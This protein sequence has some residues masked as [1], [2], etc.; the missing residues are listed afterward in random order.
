MKN[1]IIIP[2]RFKSSRFPG[3][4]LALIN[5]RSLI[6]RTWSIAK[7]I[8]HIDEVFIATDDIQIKDHVTDFGAK[9]VMTSDACQNG[10][11]RVF[12]A[13][14]NL[15]IKPDVII[16]LQG[17]A[18]LTP[19]EMIQKLLS[20]MIADP[21]IGFATLATKMTIDQY[22]VMLNLQNKGESGGTTVVFD[23]YHSAL[24][25][26]KR[27]IPF[28]KEAGYNHLIYRHIGIY[29]YRYDTL[30]EYLDLPISTLERM[31]GLEQLRAL[32]NG[33]PIHIVPVDVKYRTDWDVNNPEDIH[34]VEEII[35]KE[36]ELLLS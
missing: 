33:L 25:F 36:G 34:I 15:K 8:K 9:V 24:Y 26:S 14:N 11:E 16:N 30:K 29:A 18:P 23:K 20:S 28:I 27:L 7:T 4:P 21:S 31:E 35:K 13:V 6:F 19:P 32:E 22:N 3:K 10:T 12:E 2:A 5:N 17:D 1:V